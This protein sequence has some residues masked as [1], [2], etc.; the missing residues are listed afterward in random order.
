MLW[1]MRDILIHVHYVFMLYDV[2][3][4]TD[5]YGRTRLRTRG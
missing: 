3:R 2:S 4:P 5:I 1:L